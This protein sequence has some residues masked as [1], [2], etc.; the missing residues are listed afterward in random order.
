MQLRRRILSADAYGSLERCGA[1]SDD[2]SEACQLAATLRGARM[3]LNQ[4]SAEIV[5]KLRAAGFN[6]TIYHGFPLV[7]IPE[8]HHE[9][10]RFLKLCQTVGADRRI[11]AEGCLFV[12][13]GAWEKAE[14]DGVSE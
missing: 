1:S 2:E 10:V 12:P 11:Y 8:A 7:K 6:P 14:K 9:I 13:H 4:W 5:Q 3:T